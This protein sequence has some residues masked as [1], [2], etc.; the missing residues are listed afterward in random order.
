MNNCPVC[1]KKTAPKQI[2]CEGCWE[3]VDDKL[4]LEVK[5]YKKNPDSSDYSK[6]A[7]DCINYS[8]SL[9][10]QDLEFDQYKMRMGYDIKGS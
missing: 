9:A 8:R 1:Y 2:M 4:K 5:R 10:A 3:R 6:A 7:Q